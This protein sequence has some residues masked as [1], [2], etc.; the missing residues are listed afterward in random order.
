M[1]STLEQLRLKSWLFKDTSS[2]RGWGVSAAMC[3][4]FSARTRQHRPSCPSSTVNCARTK[5]QIQTCGT[6]ENS[7]RLL[8]TPAPDV[9]LN[10]DSRNLAYYG[11]G[12]C[13][14]GRVDQK[15]QKTRY[16]NLESKV[17]KS[18]VGALSS[19]CCGR[20]HL[21]CVHD[22]F[23][24]KVR[25]IVSKDCCRHQAQKTLQILTR[26]FPIRII[27]MKTG[28]RLEAGNASWPGPGIRSCQ[29][30]VVLV[31]SEFLKMSPN[32]R[33][34]VTDGKAFIRLALWFRRASRCPL[35]KLWWSS[36]GS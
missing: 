16:T 10:C 26:G 18:S 33:W 1:F 8:N 29:Q 30:I 24:Q 23:S 14:G 31:V 12:V 4:P 3:N 15:C 35:A 17:V 25:E 32:K 19:V 20:S 34:R 9:T 11:L 22:G 5:L 6:C 7:H 28:V 2:R 27:P 21:A 36:K 13:F